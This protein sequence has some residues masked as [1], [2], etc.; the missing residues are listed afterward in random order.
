MAPPIEIH[1]TR[2]STPANKLLLNTKQ[3]LDSK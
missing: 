2:G 1:I 3:S